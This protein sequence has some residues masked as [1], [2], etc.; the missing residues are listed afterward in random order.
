MSEIW[1]DEDV[2]KKL[3]SWITEIVIAHQNIRNKAPMVSESEVAKNVNAHEPKSSFEKKDHELKEA[4]ENNIAAEKTETENEETW[5][6]SFNFVRKNELFTK[7][8]SY[9]Q[10]YIHLTNQLIISTDHAYRQV[11]C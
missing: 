9:K 3:G 2:V 8:C 1:S 11:C 7:C 5:M 10:R 6:Q 4:E